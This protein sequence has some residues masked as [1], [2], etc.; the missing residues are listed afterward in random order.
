MR[1]YSLATDITLERPCPI[2]VPAWT[3]RTSIE[4][5]RHVSRH[6]GLESQADKK[7]IREKC[8]EV[9]GSI[10][11]ELGRMKPCDQALRNQRALKRKQITSSPESAP[12]S[13]KRKLVAGGQY[14]PLATLR[15]TSPK[16][17]SIDAYNFADSSISTRDTPTEQLEFPT[18]HCGTQELLMP[19][20]DTSSAVDQ[21]MGSGQGS[22][23]TNKTINSIG[24]NVVDPYI[25]QQLVRENPPIYEATNWS[26]NV[27]L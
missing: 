19:S 27:Y 4:W 15:T 3:S 11:M 23:S 7:Y 8:A 14:A 20:I 18:Y 6:N 13:H 24:T 25:L 1:N 22:T 5:L 9:L 12:T 2:C 21:A 10:K 17:Q 16:T 26:W